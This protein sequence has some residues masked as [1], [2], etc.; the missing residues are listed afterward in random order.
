MPKKYTPNDNLLIVVKQKALLPNQTYFLQ[1]IV[2]RLSLRFEEP[3]QVI[4]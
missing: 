4:V 1:Y 3:E 2:D